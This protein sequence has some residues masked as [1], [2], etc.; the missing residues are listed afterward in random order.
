MDGLWSPTLV[1]RLG[2]CDYSCN[3][4]GQVCPTG[5]IPS[6]DLETKRATKIGTASVDQDRCLPWSQNT[7]CIVCE[8]MCPRAPKAIELDTIKM[9]D[10]SG[11]EIELQRPRVIPE[12]CIGCGICEYKCPLEG[13]AAITVR[14]FIEPT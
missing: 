9:T 11:Q 2:Y 12:R 8:E 1:P 14:G 7:P 13:E 5:A 4:C 3:A 10:V 6:L